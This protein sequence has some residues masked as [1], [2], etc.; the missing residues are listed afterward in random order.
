MQKK[1]YQSGTFCVDINCAHHKALEPYSGEKYIEMKQDLCR[2]CYAWMF[3]NWLQKQGYR[4]VKT[5]PEISSK[6][7]AARLKGIDPVKVE[8][9][10]EDEILSL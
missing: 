8:D 7:L 2:D 10:T 5:I 6:E 9:L 3:F 4:I 1:E